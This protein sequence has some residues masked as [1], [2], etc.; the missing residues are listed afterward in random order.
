VTYG[1]CAGCGAVAWELLEEKSDY[2]MGCDS[3]AYQPPDC[4]DPEWAYDTEIGGED[5]EG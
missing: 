4:F 2:C 1:V 3:S 5:E